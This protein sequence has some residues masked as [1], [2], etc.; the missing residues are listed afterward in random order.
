MPARQIVAVISSRT[1]LARAARMRNPPD[2]FELRLDAA[3]RRIRELENAL[4]RLRAPLIITARHPK[5]GGLNQLSARERRDLL[6]QF[7][8]HAACMDVELRSAGPLRPVLDHARARN[9]RIIIS[10][11]NFGHTPAATRL[12]QIARASQSL[13]ADFLKIAT[14]TDTPAQLARL[15]DFFERQRGKTEIS[16]MGMGRLGRISRLEFVRR[17]SALNYAHLGTRQT[18]GQL[19]L[20]ELRRALKTRS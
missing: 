9:V 18:A 6:R 20:P 1:D 2:F 16:A 17:G 14:R 12:D 15:V 4:G 10:Y 11:H 3:A 8:P 5:E 13:G 7:L 19:S